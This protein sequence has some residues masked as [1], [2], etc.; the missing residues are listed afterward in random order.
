MKRGI[1]FDAILYVIVGVIGIQIID[2]VLTTANFSG[3][4]ATVTDNVPILAGVGLLVVA[5]GAAY[6]P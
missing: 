6:R 3:L 2:S 5:A 4:L 1:G